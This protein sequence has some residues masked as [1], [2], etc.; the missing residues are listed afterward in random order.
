MLSYWD[1]KNI[2]AKFAC[3]QDLGATEDT[4]P[5]IVGSEIIDATVKVPWGNAIG[6]IDNPEFESE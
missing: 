6:L 1:V 2:K 4:P 5:A 3:F